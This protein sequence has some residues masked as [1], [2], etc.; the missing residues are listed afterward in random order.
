MG[1]PAA[2]RDG[3]VRPSHPHDNR[4]VTAVSQNKLRPS[5]NRKSGFQTASVCLWVSIRY[6]SVSLYL[7][8]DTVAASAVISLR[9]LM[10]TIGKYSILALSALAIF[11]FKAGEGIV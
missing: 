5:E 2:R 8:S 1:C 3:L 4:L 11:L 10:K 7:I 9:K 6:S